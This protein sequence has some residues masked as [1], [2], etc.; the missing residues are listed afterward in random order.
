ME[1]L[2]EV[3][4]YSIEVN[5][6]KPGQLASVC[7][8]WRFVI[9]S[10]GSLWS[11]LR[12]GIR[13][14]TGQVA[15]WLRRAYPKKVVIDI[16]NDSQ[17]PSEA[18]F[19]ALQDALTSTD[20][21][22]E[23]TISSFPPE[24]L[25]SQLDFQV[26]SRMNL[27]KVLH[28][29]AGCVHSPSFASLLDLVPTEA[30][31]SELR[32]HTLFA[33]DHFLQPH[34]LPVLQNLTVLTLNGRDIHEPFQ[35]LPSFTQLRIFGADCLRL[36][37]YEPDINLPLLC[38]LRKLHLRASSVQWMAGREF[39]CL[40]ECA[41]VLPHHWVAVQQLRVELPSCRKL[42]YHGYP[43]TVA[44]Y[45]HAP[46]MRAVDLGSHDCK[47]ERVYHQFSH[48]C[49]LDGISN[50]TVLHLTLGCSER[51]FLKVLQYMGPL[52]ELVLSIA[53]PS[54]SWQG[55]LESL[56]AKPSTMDWPKPSTMD[57][58]KWVSWGADDRQWE[59][60][61][62]SQTWHASVLPHLKYLG[63]QCP[64]G[65]SK[66]E[67]LNNCP[68]FRLVGWT[69]AQLTR[70]LEQLKV[71][72][73]RGTTND[74]VVDYVSTRYL[75]K[76]VGTSSEIYDLLIVRGM[77][78]RYLAMDRYATP[79][80]QL[81]STVLFRC[82]HDLEVHCFPD[83]GIYILSCLE[84]IK[85]L[86]VWHVI[87]PEYSLN[88]DL[89]LSRTLQLLRLSFSSFSWMLGRTFTSLREIQLDEPQVSQ[90]R[91]EK[92]QADL[93]ACIT[94]KLGSFSLNHLQFFFCPNVQNL[95]LRQSPDFSAIDEAALNCLRDFLCNCPC[96][97]T[98]DVLIF[99]SLGL[100]SLIQCVFRDAWEQKVWRD[101]RSVEVKVRLTD[102]SRGDG[103]LFFDQM[104]E[105]H[106][107]YEKWWKEFK[108]TMK[109][110]RSFIVRASV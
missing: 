79:I 6:M 104:V 8:N 58:P 1:L 99:L 109:D 88:I 13:T 12:V 80:F 74:I 65:F 87:V 76:H 5:Q 9:I 103:H 34:W 23:L 20:Q 11:T 54:H 59:Q 98:L 15:T 95:H 56:A 38:T 10:T 51:V 96:L 17:S 31:L 64:K 18:S 75:D 83:H 102:S 32:L 39:R 24:N 29:A 16:Q 84:Q 77:V 86:V 82:L 36:P 22:H 97:Q 69:R 108:V 66:S 52:E 46:Q 92:L 78:T 44:Q 7:R 48:L 14:E 45:F 55:F 57:W 47:E 43:M 49:T 68:L 53:Y 19:A 90:S 2:R 71:W 63:I 110:K 61:C 101:V 85:G 3:F 107:H 25:A 60:W 70:P 100:D 4:L 72:E 42:T 89:P 73:G 105:H 50:L 106:Q 28:L 30:P 21:W 67:C 33:N 35:L 81:H 37:L 93:P 94:L 26:A 27:L 62:S 91:H 41:I 40:E